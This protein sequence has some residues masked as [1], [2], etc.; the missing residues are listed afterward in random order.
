MSAPANSPATVWAI[1]GNDSLALAGIAADLR[2]V[3]VSGVHCATIVT[4]VTAQNSLEFI[5]M[6][7]I[8]CEFLEQQWQ[9]L[10]AQTV[11]SVI[12]IGLLVDCA[13]VTWLAEKLAVLCAE[14][15]NIR[16]IY[17]PVLRA[18]SDKSSVIK[19]QV[20]N[21][22]L[23]CIKRELLPHIDLLTPNT[24]EAA[25]LL[26]TECVSMVIDNHAQMIKAATALRR[27]YQI[28]VLLK[29]GHL[30]G[31][32]CCD[33][34]LG[35]NDIN[36]KFRSEPS[37]QFVLSTP[38]LKHNNNRGT[39]CT[40]ASVIAGLVAKNYTFCDAI[41]LAK[42]VITGALLKSSALGNGKGGLL[43]LSLP[44][45]LTQ[46]PRVL[47]LEQFVNDAPLLPTSAFAPCSYNLG[48]YPVVHNTSWLE[49][50]LKL[51]INT[52]QL[53]LKGSDVGLSASEI[54]VQVIEA[55][56]LGRQY[57]ARVFIN[58]YWQLALT[59]HAYG[60]HL[61]QED[62]LLADLARI[63]SAGLRLGLSTHGI[64]EALLVNDLAPSYMA[65][66]HI[67]STQTKDMP[68]NPQGIEQL[69]LQVKLFE[70]QRSLV[71][72]GGISAARVP[73]VL[74]SGIKSIALV[75]AITHSDDVNSIVASLSDLIGVGDELQPQSTREGVSYV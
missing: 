1:G 23:S 55:I 15:P 36:G 65:L 30:V 73:S 60:V 50:L 3:A 26:S 12:K 2:G 31:N 4:C 16:I 69:A 75:T 58:D 51:G 18:S 14:Q 25:A 66:G 45:D 33:L 20:A 72:I 61:G 40:L 9:A 37:T 17:D 52:I 63:K 21:E 54:E 34:Y 64:F 70:S 46:L 28:I 68:S 49:R 59:H 19:T 62:L 44:N 41:V 13:Q 8:S 32:D 22:L 27:Q 29:G 56:A 47:T 10:S 39:G 7:A 38:R 43:S 71:A 24:V 11:P 57:N 5:A 67:F 53:R 48:L 74:S 6:Q 35:L 42:S